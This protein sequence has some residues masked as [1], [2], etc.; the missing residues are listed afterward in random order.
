MLRVFI[1]ASVLFAAVY[2]PRG[3]ARDL[4]RL[5]LEGKITLV[6]SPNILE[7]IERN[8]LRKAPRA[9]PYYRDLLATLALEIVS[10]PAQAAVQDAAAY[11]AEKDAHVIAAAI[12][13]HP[14]YLVTYDQKHLLAPPEVARRSGLT[15]VTP[16]VVVAAV[17]GD[18]GE[19]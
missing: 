14:D 9:A 17:R 7:E 3:S 19:G 10:L 13:A 5:G 15:I 16:D 2:S 6:I 4:L 18:P 1:D 11:V 12:E 8:L